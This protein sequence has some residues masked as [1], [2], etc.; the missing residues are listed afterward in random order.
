[1]VY[2]KIT[3]FR[4]YLMFPTDVMNII[5]KS[6]DEFLFMDISYFFDSSALLWAK[7]AAKSHAVTPLVILLRCWKQGPACSFTS[8]RIYCRA[9]LINKHVCNWLM[10]PHLLLVRKDTFRASCYSATPSNEYRTLVLMSPLNPNKYDDFNIHMD[11]VI[12]YG[13]TE[14]K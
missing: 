12:L 9:Y 1:M 14:G 3:S 2:R 10:R 5:G 13:F 4:P 11:Y 8:L 7:W 6:L